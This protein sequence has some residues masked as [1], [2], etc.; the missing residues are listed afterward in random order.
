MFGNLMTMAPII[1]GLVVLMLLA[2]LNQ[3]Q[4][5]LVTLARCSHRGRNLGEAFG[6]E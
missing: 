5:L 1:A 6:R 4:Y 2:R 3:G